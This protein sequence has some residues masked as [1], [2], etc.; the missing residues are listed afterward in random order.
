VRHKEPTGTGLPSASLHTHG[1]S[2][3]ESLTDERE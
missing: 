1:Y 2:H 3:S